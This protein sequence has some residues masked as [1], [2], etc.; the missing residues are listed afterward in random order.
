MLIG[1]LY[2][3][4]REVGDDSDPKDKALWVLA[5][6]LMDITEGRHRIGGAARALERANHVL[7]DPTKDK[8]GHDAA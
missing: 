8:D 6:A 3:L 7:T 1:P 2:D 5:T 4:V